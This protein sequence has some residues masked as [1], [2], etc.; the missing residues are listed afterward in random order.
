MNSLK[1]LL[2]GATLAFAGC[3]V[4]DAGDF[5]KGI[6]LNRVGIEPQY[7]AIK[8]T[9]FE[10][11]NVDNKTN[12]GLYLGKDIGFRPM[13]GTRISAGLDLRLNS[14]W[15]EEGPNTSTRHKDRGACLENEGALS[16]I[17]QDLLTIIPF[18]GL[19]Q[20]IGDRKLN[21]EI[22]LPYTKWIVQTGKAV[23]HP[24]GCFSRSE[25]GEISDWGQKI[26]LGLSTF[27]ESPLFGVFTG[28][29]LSYEIYDNELLRADVWGI[30]FSIKF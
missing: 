30:Q 17:S 7:Y 10:V 8:S 20:R 4:V 5:E 26:R 9:K 2:A 1:T 14:D 22:G 12:F 29:Y 15:A 18:V 24:L 13:E 21:L 3:T 19:E 16:I 11:P 27:D 23:A 25:T 28:V 6:S